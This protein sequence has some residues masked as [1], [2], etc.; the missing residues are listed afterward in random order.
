MNNVFIEIFSHQFM[1]YALIIGLS[2][3]LGSA[4]L[5][6]FLVL[7]NQSMIA[8][9]LS[10]V[11]FT[12]IIFGL[13]AFPNQPIYVALPIAIIASVLISY[14][15]DLKMIE[16]DAAIGVVTAFALALGLIT[17]SIAGGAFN[18]DIESLLTGY[19]LS[20]SLLDVILSIIALVVVVVFVVIFYRKLLSSSYDSVYAKFSKVNYKFLKYLL[21]AL[22]AVFI[23]LG[24]RTVG[25]LLISSFIIF[26]SIIA[27]QIS[28]GF[29]ENI[30]LSVIIAVIVILVAIIG[31]FMLS[32]A[33][34]VDLPT[35]STIVMVYSVVLV[36][37]I[38]Y[39]KVLRRS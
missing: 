8:D 13:L 1:I 31:S 4:L 34:I 18:G 19:I 24:V 21:S 6:G 9:G 26:P 17:V 32:L 29:K 12:G 7:N 5:S 22:T 16:Q 35:G 33:N 38:I 23:V 20:S 10:H 14:L 39:K 30:W 11:A 37:T 28:K 25:M 27:A 2:L 15:S 36:L 3:G